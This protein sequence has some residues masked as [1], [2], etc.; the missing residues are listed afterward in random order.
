METHDWQGF[1]TFRAFGTFFAA[2]KRDPMI[3]A[4]EQAE[5][6]MQPSYAEQVADQIIADWQSSGEVKIETLR[7]LIIKVLE[8]YD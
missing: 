8:E 6:S 5:R 3:V 2:P 4:A 7:G 1:S